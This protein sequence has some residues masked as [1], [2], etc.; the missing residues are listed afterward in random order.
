MRLE[1][2][3]GKLVA[4][5]CYRSMLILVC[6]QRPQARQPPHRRQRAP[7]TYRLWTQS[8]RAPRSP[9]EDASVAGSPCGRQLDEVPF[10]GTRLFELVVTVLD[11]CERSRSVSTV[12]LR[13]PRHHRQLLPRYAQQRLDR[14]GERIRL[15]EERRCRSRHDGHFAGIVSSSTGA[16]WNVVSAEALC[17]HSRLPRTGEYPRD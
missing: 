14:F 5:G 17:R 9:D 16:D 7:Q 4:L 15:A 12:L 1:S 10:A 13:Q 6:F 11:A 3:I 2:Y 8:D